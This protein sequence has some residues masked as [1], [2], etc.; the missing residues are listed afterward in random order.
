MGTTPRPTRKE[1]LNKTLVYRL[2]AT[3]IT[4]LIVFY[5]FGKYTP[6]VRDKLGLFFV[7]DIALGITTYYTFERAW[8]M[9]A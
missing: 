3:A 2:Y 5:V 9:W 1:S 6:Q 7:A 8:A 4:T